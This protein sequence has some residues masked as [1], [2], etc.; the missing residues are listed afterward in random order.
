M[1]VNDQYDKSSPTAP[2]AV[3]VTRKGEKIHPRNEDSPNNVAI[4]QDKRNVA[5]KQSTR[6][7]VVS[8][9]ADV[10]KI[11][12]KSN[13]GTIDTISP[14]NVALGITSAGLKA[15]E[16]IK[17]KHN[18]RQEPKSLKIKANE[19]NI[20]R[21]S[22][23]KASPIQ[24]KQKALNE[25]P[26]QQIP[27]PVSSAEVAIPPVSLQTKSVIT[28][29]ISSDDYI[30]VGKTT[31]QSTKT[32]L[33]SKKAINEFIGDV[34]YRFNYTAGYHGHNEEGDTAGNKRGSYFIIGRDNIRRGVIYVANADG[35]VP[36]VKY[37]KVSSAEA[38]HEDT[39]KSAGL[40]GYE[41]EWFHKGK[42][43]IDS[44]SLKGSRR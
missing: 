6:A 30:N 44:S 1:L 27:K 8:S 32:Q 9:V 16:Q 38:P 12:V 5:N 17:L 24:L 18:E 28:V 35:F 13:S 21:P 22:G 2:D 34:L 40:R 43:K 3:A 14:I 39:E 4:Q 19:A 31:S 10:P 36:V 33:S 37:E 29:P 20:D 15:S 11:K 23:V 42:S 26:I 41:F 7:Q 25:I